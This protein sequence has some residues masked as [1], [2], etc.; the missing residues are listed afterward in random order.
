MSNARARLVLLV[1]G[2]AAISLDLHKLLIQ[3]VFAL[4]VAPLL[5]GV[6]ARHAFESLMAR[7]EFGSV[8]MPSE[9][10]G[11]LYRARLS[12]RGHDNAQVRVASAGIAST[13]LA[14]AL[15]RGGSTISASAVMR[16]FG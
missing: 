10:S 12:L 14:R 13:G 9:A 16:A 7:S 1:P 11:S 6:V 3:A 4:L 8:L 5:L 2:R 15:T